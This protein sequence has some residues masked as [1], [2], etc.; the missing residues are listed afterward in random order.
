MI[1]KYVD[2]PEGWRYGFPKSLPDDVE[3]V[4]VWLIENGYPET[5]MQSYGDHFH[6]RHWQVDYD[7]F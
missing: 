4:E 6:V 1:V 7:D 2:P 3:N 5:V